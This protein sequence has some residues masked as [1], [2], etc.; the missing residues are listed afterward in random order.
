LPD[1]VFGVWSEFLNLKIELKK[2]LFDMLDEIKKQQIM[3]KFQLERQN[4]EKQLR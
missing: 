2:L 4:I 1:D 3:I